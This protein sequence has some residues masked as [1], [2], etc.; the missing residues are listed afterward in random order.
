MAVL[1]TLVVQFGED[2]PEDQAFAKVELDD[3]RNLDSEGN[4]KTQFAPGEE[5]YFLLHFDTT[6]LYI[7]RIDC[8]GGQVVA[9]GSEPQ[10]REQQLLFIKT[11]EDDGE[12]QLS[13]IPAGPIALDWQQAQAGQHFR[14]GVDFT[15]TDRRVE[16]TGNVPCMADATYPVSFFLYRLIPPPMVLAEEQ[17]CSVVVVVYLEAQTG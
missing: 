16:V 15:A 6:A 3:T 14:E 13:Y 5:P 17:T 8:T 9:E 11:G 2:V 10:S 12:L 4:P 1:T 7:D